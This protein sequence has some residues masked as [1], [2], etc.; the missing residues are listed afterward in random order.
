MEYYK[1]I[2]MVMK[3]FIIHWYVK[4][5]ATYCQIIKRY[6]T[7]CVKWPLKYEVQYYVVGQGQSFSITQTPAPDAVGSGAVEIWACYV[8]PLSLSFSFVNSA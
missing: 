7:N 6:K 8:I 3:H 4:I 1:A 2:K 5:S